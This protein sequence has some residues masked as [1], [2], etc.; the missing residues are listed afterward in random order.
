M[1]DLVETGGSF[2]QNPLQLVIDTPRVVPLRKEGCRLHNNC[3]RDIEGSFYRRGNRFG[4]LNA[5][6]D[7]GMVSGLGL[8]P[9]TNGLK[10]RCSTD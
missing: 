2:V 7:L 5:H 1:N 3:R 9:R 4:K 8:E 10:G 6:K